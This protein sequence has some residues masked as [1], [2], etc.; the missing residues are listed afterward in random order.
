VQNLSAQSATVNLY[1]Y[2]G[3]GALVGSQTSQSLNGRGLGVFFAPV[4]NFKGSLLIT[5]N[6]DIAAIVNVAHNA[7][8]GDTH[9]IYNASNR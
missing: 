5:A 3:D 8:S 6:R 4:S 1:Y 2:A 9:A 7:G